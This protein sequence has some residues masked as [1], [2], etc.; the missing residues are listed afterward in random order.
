MNK[1]KK[2]I[3][4]A[5]A[6]PNFMKVAPLH[7]ALAKYNNMVNSGLLSVIKISADALRLIITSLPETV[8]LLPE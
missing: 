1:K 4:V 5:G 6:R 3:S 7:R 8:V 2:I